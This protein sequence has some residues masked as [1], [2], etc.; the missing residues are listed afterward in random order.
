MKWM[1]SVNQ[2]LEQAPGPGWRIAF[3]VLCTLVLSEVVAR[4]GV[5]CKERKRNRR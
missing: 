5:W 2:W 3:I 1:D 4:F